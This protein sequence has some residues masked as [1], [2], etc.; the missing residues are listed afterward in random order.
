MQYRCSKNK[1]EKVWLFGN[2][3]W[4]DMKYSI[5]IQAYFRLFKCP[6]SI[7]PYLIVRQSRHLRIVIQKIAKLY[8]SV[9]D[10]H[11]SLLSVPGCEFVSDLR[12]THG[13]DANLYELVAVRVQ[14]K[15][16]LQIYVI[17]CLFLHL[18]KGWI[19]YAAFSNLHGNNQVKVWETCWKFVKN[20]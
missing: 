8:L 3:Y 7:F 13:A 11:G 5:R 4:N 14:R 17:F 6:Y 16:H 18:G 19:K 12:Q 1:S 9:H 10:S 2:R 15:H 20:A